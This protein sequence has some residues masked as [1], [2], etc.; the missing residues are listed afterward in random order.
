MGRRIKTRQTNYKHALGVDNSK[1][2]DINL[3]IYPNQTNPIVSKCMHLKILNEVN[4][5]YKIFEIECKTRS[6]FAFSNWDFI[7]KFSKELLTKPNFISNKK[8]FRKIFQN[9]F[10]QN[11]ILTGINKHLKTYK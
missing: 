8:I 6:K 11:L 1:I 9:K 4:D 5:C 3:L 2:A 7:G 10:S